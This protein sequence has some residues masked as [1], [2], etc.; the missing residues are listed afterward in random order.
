M[1]DKLGMIKY[2]KYMLNMAE[3]FFWLVFK[4]TFLN[5]NT[6]NIL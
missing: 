4:T 6:K 2:D 5:K 3:M 1:P